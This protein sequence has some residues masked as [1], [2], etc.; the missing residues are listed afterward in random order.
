MGKKDRFPFY[1]L[2]KVLSQRESFE[3]IEAY[4]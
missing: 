3:F 2:D 4:R 1:E